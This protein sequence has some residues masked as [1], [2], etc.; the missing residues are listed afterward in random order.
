[1]EM[2]V[3]IDRLITLR[4]LY[5]KKFPKCS[6]LKDCFRCYNSGKLLRE[7]FYHKREKR[8]LC[9]AMNKLITLDNIER[10][11][12]QAIQNQ[13]A[14]SYAVSRIFFRLSVLLLGRQEFVRVRDVPM[15]IRNS[16]GGRRKRPF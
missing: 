14:S 13:S 10:K 6:R 11:L 3:I 12:L 2:S 4:N 1:M 9:L 16:C 15:R 5:S 8:T 7:H